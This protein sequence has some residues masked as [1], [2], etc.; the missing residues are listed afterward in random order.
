MNPGC[1]LATLAAVPVVVAAALIAVPA[2][3]QPFPS[4][5]VRLVVPYPPGGSVD[6]VARSFSQPL[7]KALSQTVIVEN[8]PGANSALGMEHVVRAPA[9]GHTILVGGS[10]SNAA[11]R[12]LP[13]DLLRDLTPVVGVGTQPYVFSVH[14][15]VPAKTVK[16]LVALARAR[17]GELAY[18]INIYGGGQHLSGELL[19]IMARIDMKPVVF[20]GGAPSAL[21]VLGGHAS[22]LIS[23]IAPMQQHVSTG[24]LRPLSVT[25]RERSVLLPD[26]PTMI[27]LGYADFDVT[28]AM[29]IWAPAAT[30]KEA[31]DRLSADLM[32]TLQ[33]A[34]VKSVALRDG[35]AIAPIGSTEYGVLVRKMM[36][37]YQKIA[38]AAKIK[39]D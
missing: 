28:G 30:P 4:K 38:K 15:S 11:L 23:T 14:P 7:A 24:K 37:H 33:T 6:V 27:E 25:S 36:Q 5:V 9:D 10:V 32:R 22:I 1:S 13:F 21:A 29:A 16:E 35:Y 18:S 26:I 8:R 12:K 39:L 2:A 19:K 3:G 34:D 20:Q 31:I 17:P